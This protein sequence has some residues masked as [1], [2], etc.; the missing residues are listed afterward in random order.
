MEKRK[1]RENIYLARL[2]LA[3][4]PKNQAASREGPR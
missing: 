3:I 1:K 2:F 4:H